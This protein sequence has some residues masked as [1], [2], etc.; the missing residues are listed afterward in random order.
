MQ[1][2]IDVVSSALLLVSGAFLL[3]G[4][5]TGVWKWR[6]MMTRSSGQAHVY[7]DTAHRAALMYSFAT[8]VLAALAAASAWPIWLEGVAAGAN[9]LFFASAVARY[10]QLG[11]TEA[12]DNQFTERNFVTTTGMYLLVAGEVGGLVVLIAGASV[13]L[14]S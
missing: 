1:I 8:L 10:C 4:M 5:L 13:S 6:Q 2:H 11:W 3:V 12:T 9:V 14:V 7:V